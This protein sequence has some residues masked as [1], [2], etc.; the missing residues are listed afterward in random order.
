MKQTIDSLKLKAEHW[1][2]QYR[3]LSN[4][5]KRCIQKELIILNT[6]LEISDILE[7]EH[8]FCTG[9]IDDRSP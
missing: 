9:G 5:N 6:Y 8:G 4:S 2:E 7:E 3:D 1:R